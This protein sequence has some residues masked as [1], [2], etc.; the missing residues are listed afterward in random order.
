MQ[1]LHLD[2]WL[3]VCRLSSVSLEPGY[4][5]L[6]KTFG[7]SLCRSQLSRPITS[8]LTSLMCVPFSRYVFEAYSSSQYSVFQYS[9]HQLVNCRKASS[10]KQFALKFHL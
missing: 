8:L 4:E 5:H 2:L 3:L 10:A 6:D 9:V 7:L 1:H